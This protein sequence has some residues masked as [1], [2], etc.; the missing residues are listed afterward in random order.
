MENSN[1]DLWDPEARKQCL[2]Q[3]M[4]EEDKENKMVEIKRINLNNPAKDKVVNSKEE[5]SHVS[6]SEKTISE[7]HKILLQNVERDMGSEILN[8]LKNEKSETD[9]ENK[10]HDC[11]LQS[12]KDN[13]ISKDAYY[14]NIAKEVSSRGTCL[15]R[16]YGAVIVKNDEI[17]STGYTGAPRGRVNCNVIGRCIRQERNVPSGERYEICRSVHAEMNAII[18]ASRKDM[19]GATLYLYGWDVE[20]NCEKKYPK[21]CTLCERMIINSGI[22]KVITLYETIYVEDLIDNDA[23]YKDLNIASEA[24]GKRIYK[25]MLNY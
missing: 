25:K 17:V 6:Y 5:K 8:V 4:K 13:R 3:W 24:G 23:S 15:R 19:I 20:N 21:P 9:N 11:Y 1:K 14:L 10:L 12:L 2:R 7:A 16:N 22:K 18:S